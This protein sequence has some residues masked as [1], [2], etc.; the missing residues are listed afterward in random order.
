M[1]KFRNKPAGICSSVSP[2]LDILS[3]S[4]DALDDDS[5]ASGSSK[6]VEQEK[7]VQVR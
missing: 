7:A 3:D 2:E 6:H 5:S 1:F 4:V